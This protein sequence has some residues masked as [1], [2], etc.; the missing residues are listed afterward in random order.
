MT[1][2]AK[3][4]MTKVVKATGMALLSTAEQ[5]YQGGLAC[6]DT[7]TGLVHVDS[8]RSLP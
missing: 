7:S 2:L 5:V 6:F 8:N 1:A 3:M 4:R